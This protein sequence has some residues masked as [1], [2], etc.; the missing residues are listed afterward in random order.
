MAH[1]RLADGPPP[2]RRG[3]STQQGARTGRRSGSEAWRDPRGRRDPPRTPG[4]RTLRTGVRSRHAARFLVDGEVRD[5]GPPRHRRAQGARRHRQADGQPSLEP[6]RPARR[7]SL[8]PLDQHDRRAGVSRDRRRRSH[9]QR[10]RFDAVRPRP[11][12]CRRICRISSPDP[13][14]RHALELQLRR[15]QPDH[16]RS[17]PVAGPERLAGR[18]ALA[19]GQ[20]IA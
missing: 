14:P 19:R 3:R 5:P 8:A 9:T 12:R 16:R 17:D 6:R 13:R 11:A 10:R 4:R 20:G 15:H 1:C 7:D 2:G 18:A